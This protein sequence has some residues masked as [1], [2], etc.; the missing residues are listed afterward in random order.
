MKSFYSKLLL[1]G[2]YALMFGGKA[3]AVPFTKY[4]GQLV[5]KKASL[6]DNEKPG[7]VS[8]YVEWLK[9]E[10]VNE[11]LTFSLDVSK[12]EKDIEEGL[13]FDSDVPVQ[14]GVGSSG[15]LCAAVFD[16]YSNIEKSEKLNLKKLKQDFSLMESYFHGR[17]SGIDPLVSY[18]NRPVLMD[19]KKIYLPD[20]DCETQC[21]VSLIDTGIT[22]STLPLVKIFLEKMN[23]PVFLDHFNNEFLPANNGAIDAFLQNDPESLFR[24]LPVIT[25]FQ[26]SFLPEMIPPGYEK[27]ISDLEHEGIFVKL[28]GSGG[29]GYLL[30]FSQK[31]ASHDNI[32]GSFKVL[33]NDLSN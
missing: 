17:S 5:I 24:H 13:F 3:L 18:L 10:K 28:L 16:R 14:Y 27:K 31:K 4:R 9:R 20:L 8:D 30:A 29:G 21:S 32:P 11:R 25:A 12:M 22:A 26:L 33:E 6:N 23:N 19:Q 15:V 2:E 1:F 7:I